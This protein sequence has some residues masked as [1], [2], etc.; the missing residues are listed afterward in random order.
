MPV[1]DG[2][3]G[4]VVVT[5]VSATAQPLIR[6]AT[7]DISARIAGRC[8]CGRG[9]GLMER[10][11]G[12]LQHIIRLPGGHVLDMIMASGVFAFIPEVQRYQVREIRPGR[13]QVAV[14]AAPGAADKVSEIVVR[15]FRSRLPGVADPEVVVC[16]SLPLAPSGK[17]QTLVPFNPET[18]ESPA[19]VG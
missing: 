18:A 1:P 10:V 19:S 17:F 16:D 7:G 9:L 15:A 8:S 4:R 14:I 13:L 2:T 5:L 3:P 6:Y 12:R 11:H